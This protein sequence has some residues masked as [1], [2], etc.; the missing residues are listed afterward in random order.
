MKYNKP[1]NNRVHNFTTFFLLTAFTVLVFVIKPNNRIPL[2]TNIIQ[3]KKDKKEFKKDRKEWMENMHRSSPDIDWKIIDKETRRKKF[4]LNTA[5]RIANPENHSSIRDFTNV[6]G[7][8]F[9]RGSNNQA[10]RILTSYI[11]HEN[12]TIY[13]ASSGGNIWRGNMDGSEWTSLNDYFQ[14]KG[15]HFLNRFE[16]GDSQRMIMVNS[17]NL[18]FTDDEGYIIEPAT[19]LEN[20][21]NWGWIFRAVK[22]NDDSGTLYLAVIEWDY[23]E[24]TH[25]PAI[26]RSIDGG[27]TFSKI[28]ELSEPNGYVSG[29]NH[30][31]IWISK[32]PNAQLLILNDGNIYSLND[33]DNT[34]FI[35]DM[36]PS[37]SGN[38]ILIG[39]VNN[40]LTFL[41]SRIG[42]Q[43]YSSIDGGVSWENNG[44]LPTG[45]FT[46]NSFE[47]PYNN[48][49]F[50]VVGSVDGYTTEDRGENWTLINNWWEYY[51]DPEN[52]LHADLPEFSFETDPVTGEEFQLICTD[53]GIYISYDNL[54]N[55][56]NISM[57]GLGVSQYYS[58]YTANNSP[59]HI[60]AGS[61][62][63]GFQRHLNDGNEYDGVLDFE[64]TISGDYGHIVSSDGG[65][66]LW[67]DYPGFVMY[68]ADAANSTN[69]VS[70]DFAGSGYLWL[71]PIMNDPNQSNIVYIGGGGIE[72]QNHMVKVIYGAGGMTA[73]D[74]EFSFPSKISA[75]A[76]S[77]LTNNYWYV[78][79]EDGKFYYST[80]SGQDFSQTSSFT[81][82]E[83]HY[84]YGSA[85]LPSPI[86]DSRIYIAGSGYSNPA[87][88][89]SED[90][91][92]SF[93]SFNN[94]LPNTLVYGLA[95]LPDESMI[96][97]ATEVG[98]YVF[99][100]EQ[101][102]WEDMTDG[103]F[104]PDQ[105][106]WSVEYIE[107][108][109]TVR[110][111]TYGRGIWDYKF[112]YDPILTLGDLN[113]DNNVNIDDLIF[114]ISILISDQV[115]TDQTISL[116]D[117]NYD[118]TLDIFD[119]LLL[120][121]TIQ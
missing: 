52:K 82:P 9:E 26:Y 107:N 102:S 115:I 74:L 64:Q 35:G 61:Q 41:H 11:D 79:T 18:F 108:I 13:C 28:L 105:T 78:S 21:Q 96:F 4:E 45:T 111:G 73:F 83:S 75:M 118:D 55:V 69:M 31:D 3:Q 1:V 110:F 77:P 56:E 84:F 57:S 6:N 5:N 65:I 43:L 15:I 14:I 19:G 87:I 109:H 50:I 76:Y 12:E 95:I 93:T 49:N 114:L 40:N 113:E 91:G 97:A 70:W 60:Y 100:F 66:S 101:G 68:Y 30:F 53:G 59:H 32:E 119:L 98:P 36:D 24:W 38:N 37:G 47:C 20:V 89:V 58:T 10:G 99:S 7:E 17:K 39:G 67:T 25:L 42:N 8:W 103:G 80:D 92:N 112:D 27:A 34:S 90:G 2:P 104:A 54:E 72:S 121:D 29:D 23:T 16:Y 46:I 22:R 85:I 116:G 48:Q 88:Y 71:P 63:Q 120:A 62:D 94:G 81:G 86:N 44:E 51:S 117:F 33:N 106:Y